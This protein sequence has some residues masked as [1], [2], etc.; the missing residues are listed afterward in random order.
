[1]NVLIAAGSFKDVYNPF[2]SCH[3]IKESLPDIDGNIDVIPMCD[4]GEYSYDVLERV[5]GY[6][7]EIAP[8]I[9]NAYGKII[10]VRYLVKNNEAHII[11][12]EVIRLYPIEDIYKNPLELSDYGLGQ[13]VLDAI[14]KGYSS[15]Y[16]YIGGTATATAGMGFAQALGVEIIDKNGN[17]FEEMIVSKELCNIAEI[18]FN[19]EKYSN[20]S[21]TVVVDGDAKSY[22]IPS[23]TRL[24]I[25]KKFYNEA[26]SIIEKAYAGIENVISLSGISPEEPFSGAAGGLL[27]G[28]SA[29]FNANYVLGVNHFSKILDLEKFIAQADYVITGEGRLD[30]T[31]CGKTPASV[32]RMASD[33]GKKVIYVCGQLDDSIVCDYS[34]GIVDG[35]LYPFLKEMGIWKLITCRSSYEKHPIESDSYEVVINE[36]KNRM[37]IILKNLFESV[38]I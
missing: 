22:D 21:L 13:V 7:R 37:P 4:G 11:S 2:E 12:S 16:L 27:Y 17:T 38:F 31:A 14:N 28:I 36:Y 18:R 3:I 10:D 35:C 34:S 30:N 15:I 32:A 23:I 19:K 5:K 26:D 33:Y 29:V 6:K 20:I 1:M 24:K 9:K 8:N 25:G